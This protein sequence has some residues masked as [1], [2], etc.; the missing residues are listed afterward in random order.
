MNSAK[1]VW[2]LIFSVLP[3]LFALSLASAQT[4]DKYYVFYPGPQFGELGYRN[5]AFGRLPQIKLKN[6]RPDLV[7]TVQ[8]IGNDNIGIE[9]IAPYRVVF[10]RIAD[11]PKTCVPVAFPWPISNGATSSR[12]SQF[13]FPGNCGDNDPIPGQPN[14]YWN[15]EESFRF[16]APVRRTALDGGKFDASPMEV[17]RKGE[18]WMTLFW[19]YRL[20]L[21][22]STFNWSAAS[23][24]QLPELA[25]W[26]FVVSKNF[27]EFILLTLPPPFVEDDVVEYVNQA[28]FPAQPGGQYFY[29]VRAEDK[30]L[31]DSLPVWQRSGKGFKS[32][33]YVSACR[34]YG[35]KN[36]GPNTH[37]Y[38][39]DDKECA[40]LKTIPQLS[41]EGQTFAANMPL[42]GAN[43]DGTKPC[44]IDSKPLYRVYN[45]ASASNGRFVSNHRYF[46]E[47][48]DVAA[49]VAQG[50]VDEGQVM[51]VPM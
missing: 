36:G 27:G 39:A 17:K 34:F 5:G 10:T 15:I 6:A 29:A 9:T 23:L 38:S 18:A 11:G 3:S 16:G 28:N 40:A 14:D 51:C 25:N 26:P 42:S 32:G 48:T 45:N 22:E 12:Q 20:G 30:T 37:F 8:P 31:L 35:G 33:G 50:W 1:L 4:L 21:V 43:A 46:T 24:A 2:K 19:G 47:K 7:L 13:S 41:Y 49:V 44:P